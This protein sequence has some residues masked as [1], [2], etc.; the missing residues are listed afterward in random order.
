[1]HYSIGGD[2]PVPCVHGFLRMWSLHIIQGGRER[3][4]GKGGES[5]VILGDQME[6]EEDDRLGCD[7]LIQ[8]H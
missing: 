3:R 8:V 7:H 1:M 5:M 2:R 4:K 6:E